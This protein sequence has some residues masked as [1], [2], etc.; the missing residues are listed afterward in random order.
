MHLVIWLDI[1]SH[2]DE[3]PGCGSPHMYKERYGDTF[4]HFHSF[5]C[6]HPITCK[7][8]VTEELDQE[9]KPVL[10]KADPNTGTNLFTHAKLLLLN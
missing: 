7:G 5:L 1:L 6:F 3:T 9:D 4:H 2:S 10:F 8:S